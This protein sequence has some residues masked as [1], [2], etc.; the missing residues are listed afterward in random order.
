[1]LFKEIMKDEGLR[2]GYGCYGI[3]ASEKDRERFRSL[4]NLH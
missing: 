4:D 2:I 1:M 3:P